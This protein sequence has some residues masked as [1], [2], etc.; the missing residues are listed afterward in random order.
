MSIL[1]TFKINERVGTA[2]PTCALCNK[3]MPVKRIYSVPQ[4]NIPD[5]FSCNL[6]KHCRIFIMFGTHVTRK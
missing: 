5:I 6:R 1:L 2:R 3:V 4:Q